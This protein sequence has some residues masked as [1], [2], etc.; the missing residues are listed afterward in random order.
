MNKINLKIKKISKLAQLPTYATEGAAGMDLY[1][2]NEEP[3]TLAP[4]ERKLVPLG[5]TMEL[6]AGYEAQIRPRSG[7]AIKRGI[8]LSNC[9]GTVDEDYRG[10]VCVGLVNLSREDYTINA[11]DRIAQMVV[12]PVTKAVIIEADELAETIRG[13]GGFGST[14]Y[15]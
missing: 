11:G 13:E 2:A 5:F 10:E 6:P 1:A 7:M 4:L 3:I 15:N 14:G 12:A 9:V 8:T